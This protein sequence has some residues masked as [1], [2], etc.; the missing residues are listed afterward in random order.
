MGTKIEWCQE[1]W[2]PAT[3]CTK[4]SEG[5]Q[6]CYAERMARRLAGR[7]GYPPKPNQFKPTFHPDR[8]NVPTKWKN[9]R[10]IFVCSMSDIFHDDVDPWWIDNILNACLKAPQHTYLF[11]TKRPHNIKKKLE[12][13]NGKQLDFM[14]ARA[15][16]GATIEN[17][18][19]LDRIDDLLSV[20]AAVRFVSVEPML[21]QVDLRKWFPHD[22]NCRCPE[23]YHRAFKSQPKYTI[24]WVICGGESGPGARPMHPDWVWSLRDQCV[25]AGVPFFFKQWGEFISELDDRSYII[26]KKLVYDSSFVEIVHDENS[27]PIDYKGEYMVRVGKKRAGRLLDGQEW[28]QYPEASK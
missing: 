13:C 9:P 21:G 25:S 5:C 1:T 3:G 26:N 19:H 24:D 14:A 20:S 6:N 22:A 10:R 7:Y 27:V 12:G 2:S 17:N 15:W 18:K 28:N 8:L 11:L 16:I 4:I 23:C